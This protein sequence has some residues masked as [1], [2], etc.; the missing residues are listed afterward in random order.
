M[1]KDQNSNVRRFHKLAKSSAYQLVNTDRSEGFLHHRSI[2]VEK[3]EKN[4]KFYSFSNNSSKSNSRKIKKAKRNCEN[5]LEFKKT[6]DCTEQSS[7]WKEQR[8]H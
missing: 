3:L 1:F 6:S 7:Q 8:S 2:K 5:C 4:A